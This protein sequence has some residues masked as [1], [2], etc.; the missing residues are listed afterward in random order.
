MSG[1]QSISGRQPP[2]PKS[3]LPPTE[4]NVVD[5]LRRLVSTR[6]WVVVGRETIDGIPTIHLRQ[7]GQGYTSNGATG[8]TTNDL[9]V[10]AST[11]YPVKETSIIGGPTN[12][13]GIAITSQDEL[14]PRTSENLADLTLVVPTGFRHRTTQR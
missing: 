6:E 1:S 7:E 3:A 11:Y 8:T 10:D 2:A 14:I 12:N 4:S 9:W 13:V 5:E